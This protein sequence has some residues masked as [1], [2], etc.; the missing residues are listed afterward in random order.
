MWTQSTG[1][2]VG[3]LHAPY[4]AGH[5]RQT[6]AE[7]GCT[8][9]P[10]VENWYGSSTFLFPSLFSPLL[11]F[12]MYVRACMDASKRLAGKALFESHIFLGVRYPCTH[13]SCE[14]RR[15]GF[16]FPSSRSFCVYLFLSLLFPILYHH[17]F[18]PQNKSCTGEEG[19]RA[20]HE[21]DE[22]SH[23]FCRDT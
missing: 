22:K 9:F 23:F 4:V 5:T 16:S 12:W 8:I 18:C 14:R 13:R 15:S 1:V 6:G 20:T 19:K 11:T 3:N 7:G 21:S 17:C 10:W 2:V